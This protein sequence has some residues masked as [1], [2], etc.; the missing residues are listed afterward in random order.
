MSNQARNEAVRALAA[1]SVSGVAPYRFL[2]RGEMRASVGECSLTTVG[3]VGDVHYANP[4]CEIFGAVRVADWLFC[5]E[6][7]AAQEAF[8]LGGFCG[9][10]H[11]TF[12]QT[13]NSTS[14]LLHFVA[15]KMLPIL[16]PDLQRADIPIRYTTWPIAEPYI[17]Q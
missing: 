6:K 4:L 9:R 15:T 7:T 5:I 16:Q 10:T 1:S 2:V 3:L 11:C 17:L 12:G 13:P 8:Y 14:A